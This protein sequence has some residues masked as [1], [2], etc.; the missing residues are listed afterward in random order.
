MHG[1]HTRIQDSFNTIRH[2][3]E[4]TAV[5]LEKLRAQRDDYESQGKL[6]SPNAR[7]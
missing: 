4:S 5:E 3:M 6:Y 1:S 7:I 2:E